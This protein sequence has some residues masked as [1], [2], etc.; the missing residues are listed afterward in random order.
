MMKLSTFERMAADPV[1]FAKDRCESRRFFEAEHGGKNPSGT[2]PRAREEAWGSVIAQARQLDVGDVVLDAFRDHANAEAA[3]QGQGAGNQRGGAGVIGHVQDEGAVDLRLV[4]GQV[5]QIGQRAVPNIHATREAVAELTD[6]IP[7][8]APL[9][10]RSRDEVT[11]V[12]R[13]SL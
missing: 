1:S 12:R 5:A 10:W 13:R 7:P 8:T 6:K 2:S 11:G 4:D 9:G 3:G